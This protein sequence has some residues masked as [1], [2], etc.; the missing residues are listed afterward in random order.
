M[1]PRP[2]LLR[3]WAPDREQWL[4]PAGGEMPGLPL[5]WQRLTLH[6]RYNKTDHGKFN[7]PW[8]AITELFMPSL[9]LP[10]SQL[11]GPQPCSPS[12]LQT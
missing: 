10:N 5:N 9:P 8:S 12:S 7:G 3:S 11:L 1:G 2:R 6:S 4:V